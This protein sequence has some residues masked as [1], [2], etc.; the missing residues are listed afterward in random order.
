MKVKRFMIIILLYFVN[1][2]D[3]YIYENK[4][5]EIIYVLL[6]DEILKV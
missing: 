5:M 1:F 4:N 6:I 3:F 2:D